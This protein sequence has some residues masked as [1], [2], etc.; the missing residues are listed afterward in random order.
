[1]RILFFNP[2][3][4]VDFENEPSNYE[5][6]LPILNCGVVTSYKDYI[7][8]RVLR[9]EGYE[10]MNKKALQETLE[11]QPDLVIYSTSW[12]DESIDYSVLHEIRSWSIPIYIHVWDTF[13][14]PRIKELEWFLSCSYFGVGDSVTNYI[15]YRS[16]LDYSK[17]N[18]VIFTPGHNVFT[19]FIHKKK[20]EKI[21]DVTLLGSNEGE[22]AKL[23]E[24]LEEKLAIHGISLHKFGG[25]VDNT[26]TAPVTNTKLRLTDKWVPWERYVNIIN[27]SKICLSSQTIPWRC[28]IK[29]KIFEIMACGVLCISDSNPEIRKI[30]PEDCIVYYENFEDCAN[31]IVYYIKHEGEREKIAEKGYQWFK[32]TFNYKNFWSKFLKSAVSGSSTMPTLPFLE[33]VFEEYCSKRKQIFLR[34]LESIDK[35]MRAE[36]LI[37]FASIYL[38]QR[39]YKEA[40]ESL[41]EALSIQS[42]DDSTKVNIIVLFANVY[43]Q[44]KKYEKAEEKFKEAVSLKPIDQSLRISIPYTLGSLYEMKGDFRKAIEVFK[45]IIESAKNF[46]LFI[47]KNRF[48]GGAH[49][50]LGSIYQK[51]GDKKRAKH[52]FKECLKFI[53]NHKKAREYLEKL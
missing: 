4:Y 33:N 26:K 52:H 47:N 20:M 45:E 15:R 29:G 51:I 34:G 9:L 24:Y 6:R 49:F 5:L 7:Y 28:Q 44:Q 18:G 1:M 35:N 42:L 23:I 21:Y 46:P 27:Q 16:M 53:P 19:D 11:F 31:K 50:H 36:L 48:V 25:L 22:R 2:E 8:Q 12:D 41:R 30:V 10:S 13:I 38:Q 3:Q 40:E 37:G 43:L 39:K 14:K 32:Q 17:T